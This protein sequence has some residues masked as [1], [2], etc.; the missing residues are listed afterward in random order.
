MT[1]CLDAGPRFWIGVAETT[2]QNADPSYLGRLLRPRRE[3]PHHCSAAKQ[4]DEFTA[5]KLIELHSTLFRPGPYC[6]D[7]G[8]ATISQRVY[9][10]FLTGRRAVSVSA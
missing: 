10:P 8:L 4:G 7:I 9:E 5:S 1:E 2:E 6:K 3:R